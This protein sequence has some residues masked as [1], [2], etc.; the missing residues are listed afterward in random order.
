MTSKRACTML[1]LLG[2][3]M[4]AAPSWAQTYRNYER[5]GAFRLRAGLFQPEGSSEYWEEK[6]VDF[7]G[8]ID[9]FENV[10]IGGDYLWSFNRRTGLLL[11]GSY[12]KGDSTNSY[13]DFVDNFGNRIRHDTTLQVSSLTAGF[14]L[15]LTGPDA[16]VI[17]YLAAGGGI[18]FWNLE[19]AG[20]FIDFGPSRPEVFTARLESDGVAPGFFGLVGF[21]VPFGRTL[22]F[23]AEG[24]W[25][26]AE[27]KLEGDFEG[28]GDIDLSGREFAAGLSWSF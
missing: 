8:D 7:T 28:F 20:D 16:A 13:R 2:F 1:V 15:Q 22:S 9:D 12:F 10:S 24:R 14:H 21:E 23:F 18:Y 4:A 5:D 3:L 25:T 27:D 19:E 6:E 11:S 17:P 26:R